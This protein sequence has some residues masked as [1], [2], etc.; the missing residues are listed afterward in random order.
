MMVF[1]VSLGSQ[2]RDSQVP[3]AHCRTNCTVFSLWG[4]NGHITHI[5][6]SFLIG[7][8]QENLFGSSPVLLF[9]SS[10]TY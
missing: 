10:T 8:L 7:H 6:I 2:V 4:F 9:S 1:A 5:Y 3:A